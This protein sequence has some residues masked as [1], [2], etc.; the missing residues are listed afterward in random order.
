MA[1]E[2][3]VYMVDGEHIGKHPFNGDPV[4]DDAFL[5]QNPDRPSYYLVVVHGRR[6]T[7][8]GDLELIVDYA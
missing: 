8:E 4:I 2:L 5:M 7:Q 1:V 6:W 3:N